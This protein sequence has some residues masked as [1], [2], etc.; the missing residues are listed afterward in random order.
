[1]F[2]RNTIWSF[3]AQVVRLITALL[4]IAL[5]DP[6]A[7]GFQSLLVLL[8]TLLTLLALLGVSSATPVLLQRGVAADR[9][10]RNL[11]GLGLLVLAA[12]VLALPPLAPA[13]ARFLSGEYRVTPGDVLVGLLLLPPLLL[14][15]YLRAILLALR[16]LRQVA[17]TQCA[18]ALAQ[19]LAA[20]AL[21]GGLRLGPRGALWAM[22]LGAWIGF[23]WT[24]RAVWRIGPP[25]PRLERAVL[26]PLLSLGLRGHVGN[27]VQT[28]NYRLDALLVQGFLGQAAVGLYQT[29]VLLAELLW[30]L[31]NAVSAA[32]LPQIA[33]TGDRTLT[34][35]ATRQT[36]LLTGLGALGLL[37]V[38]W[39][40][41]RWLRPA[42]LGAFTPLAV[43]LVGV[44]ALSIHKVLAGDL[45]GRGLPQ[46]PSLTSSVALVV[47]VGLDLL[48]IPR[49]GIVGA[50]LASTLAYTTQTVILLWCYRRVSGVSWRA[51]LVPRRADL[52]FYRRLVRRREAGV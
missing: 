27:V 36:V 39:P 10:M 4:L 8:P 23:G 12:L 31:P 6:A 7:R 26:R 44:V 20:L 42:Y 33:A 41:L 17:L 1:M 30:Y 21:V 52:A 45:S 34:P 51:L 35:R 24:L 28:F 9:L 25:L 18:T 47:T 14:G 19:L 13:I 32:L 38:A 16:D 46:Y 43:L 15:E 22:V 49:L 48:L 3:G 11:L 29:G 5:L 37:I 2:L 50:A 40:A